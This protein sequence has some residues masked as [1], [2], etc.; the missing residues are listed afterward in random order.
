MDKIENISLNLA[1][2]VRQPLVVETAANILSK[3]Q[4]KAKVLES[5]KSGENLTL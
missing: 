4:L 1:P 2:Y 5:E 3:K